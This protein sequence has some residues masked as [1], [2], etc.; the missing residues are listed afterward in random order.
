MTVLKWLVSLALGAS[1]GV[2]AGVAVAE[3][4]GVWGHWRYPNDPSAGSGAIIVV[5]TAP[6]GLAMGLVAGMWLA[7]RWVKRGKGGE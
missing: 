3:A 5:L 1:L 6:V 4:V 7:E 2:A